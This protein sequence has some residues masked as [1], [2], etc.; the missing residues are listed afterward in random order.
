MSL[1]LGIVLTP[2]PFMWLQ[3]VRLFHAAV[4]DVP[5]SVKGRR[6]GNRV[7]TVVFL[8]YHARGKPDCVVLWWYLFR[9]LWYFEGVFFCFPWLLKQRG[10]DINA[11]C[12]QR[13][14]C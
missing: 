4:C 12:V 3:G 1:R 11:G 6:A 8:E 2:E 10:S 9:E 5:V 14:R 7:E 13:E